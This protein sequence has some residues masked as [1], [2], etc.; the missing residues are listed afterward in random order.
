MSTAF[1]GTLEGIK[2][3]KQNQ[4]LNRKPRKTTQNGRDAGQMSEI[5]IQL[6]RG[7]VD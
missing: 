5:Y 4:N 2:K 1:K 7:I 6:Q 3:V